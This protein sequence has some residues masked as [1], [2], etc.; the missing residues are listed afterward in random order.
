MTVLLLLWIGIV[1]PYPK[2]LSAE[3][4]ELPPSVTH[5]KRRRLERQ[6]KEMHR[7]N[8]G[9]TFPHIVGNNLNNHRWNSPQ[10]VIYIVHFIDTII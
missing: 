9:A 5:V 10:G 8:G 4:A 2:G 3:E 1:V 6:K 7:S